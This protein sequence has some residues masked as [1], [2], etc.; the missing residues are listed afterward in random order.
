M[1][2]S[3]LDSAL[4]AVVELASSKTWSVGL[5]L[6]AA[7]TI[8]MAIIQIAKDL[9][10]ARRAYQRRWISGWITRHLPKS[11]AENRE[12]E[13]HRVA[14]DLVELSAGGASDAFYELPVEE[15]VLLVNSAMTIGLDEASRYADLIAVVSDG[16]SAEDLAVVGQGQ[17]SSGSTAHYFECR[18]RVARRIQRNLDGMRI[19]LAARWRFWMHVCALG[20]TVIVVQAAM[21]IN[22]GASLAQHLMAIPIAVIGGH[23]API[24]RDI[25]A[26]IQ[27]LRT[28]G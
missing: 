22:G 24:A 4:N 16:A 27:K 18:N 11:G 25:V 8:S 10:P 6:L 23:L 12:P 2:S 19:G 1:A 13:A 21:L 17:P 14:R 28:L 9:T 26:A 3:A 15:M 7:A 20:M 5:A